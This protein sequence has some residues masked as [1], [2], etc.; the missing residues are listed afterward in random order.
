MKCIRKFTPVSP[1]DIQ[2]LESWLQDLAL[3]GLYL[4]WFRPLFSTFVQDTPRQ[5]RYRV[6]FCKEADRD[7][8]PQD[9]KDLYRD[10]GW[11]YMGRA[12]DSTLL[13]FRTRDSRAEEPHTDPPLQGELLEKLA[14]RL[15]R[16]FFRQLVLTLVM[17][18]LC[19]VLMG[20]APVAQLVTHPQLSVFLLCLILS[21]LGLPSPF[22]SWR[23]TIRLARQLGAG[24][25]LDHQ[26]PYPRHNRKS[27]AEFSAAVVLLGLLAFTWFWDVS[28]E[29]LHYPQQ[30]IANF[31]PLPL[32]SLERGPYAGAYNAHHSLLC[33]DQW[34]VCQIGDAGRVG[35]GIFWKRMDIHWYRPVLPAL[36]EPVARSLLERAK[37][38]GDDKWWTIPWGTWDEWTV[39]EY[40]VDGLDW[41]AVAEYPGG[42]FHLA[43]LSGN[44]RAAVVQYTGSGNLADHL[45]ELAG[46]VE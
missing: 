31:T 27:L 21:L 39:T 3:Q 14:R 18:V 4:A 12:W 22:R 13:I 9:L 2:G 33:W 35:D 44:G 30:E 42:Y 11:D 45:E 32:G 26:V 40:H 46:M 37:W 7:G 43:A 36:A 5:V 38:P 6:E 16:R 24:A 17:A 28:G 19:A 29:N 25:P 34:E 15:G 20:P 8:P 10:F 1:Y 23:R 41:C